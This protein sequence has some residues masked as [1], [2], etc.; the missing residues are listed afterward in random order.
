MPR[1]KAVGQ[2]KETPKSYC[3][4]CQKMLSLDKFYEATNPMLDKNG[5]MS[6]CREHCNEI[7]DMYFSIHNNLEIALQLTCEDL[8]VR[9]SNDALIQAKSHIESLLTKGK[10]TEKVFGFYKSKLGSTNKSNLKMDSFRYKDSDFN[11]IKEINPEDFKNVA[12]HDHS[13]VSDISLKYWGQNR[14]SWEYEYLEEEIYKIKSSFECP[15]YGM[16][17]IMRDIS[18]INLDIEKIRQSGKDTKGD[19]NKLIETRSKLM[20]DAKM[21]PIQATGAEANDQFTFGTL[22]KKLENERPTDEPLDEW[23]DPDNFEKWQKI[24]VGHLAEMNDIDNDTVKEYK[25]I[26]KPYTVSRQDEEEG[27]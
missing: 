1:P 2:Q 24:F 7:Y 22:I 21:K 16:E 12:L 15:D 19:I 9:F 3:R 25:E 5:L 4:M 14:E 20:N 27:E 18:F 6:I 13:N 17:M 8:D 11:Y 10:T 23:K 26:I